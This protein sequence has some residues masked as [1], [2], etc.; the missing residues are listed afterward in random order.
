MREYLFIVFIMNVLMSETRY[1][2]IIY[3]PR[4]VTGSNDELSSSSGAHA[5]DGATSATVSSSYALNLDMGL[6]EHTAEYSAAVEAPAQEIFFQVR[7]FSPYPLFLMVTIFLANPTHVN[8]II[9]SL[10]RRCL[11]SPTVTAVALATVELRSRWD[12]TPSS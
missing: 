3:P 11:T 7:N 12:R 6:A 10:S 4:G 8:F 5:A 2:T 9:H 1:L